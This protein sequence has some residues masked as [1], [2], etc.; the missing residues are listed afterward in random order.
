MINR[1]GAVNIANDAELYARGLM[2]ET[3]SATAKMHLTNN[4]NITFT[5]PFIENTSSS[6]LTSIG[7]D[8]KEFC[9]RQAVTFWS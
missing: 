2:L 3:E 6:E 8:G 7:T 5:T 4:G 9:S 1:D